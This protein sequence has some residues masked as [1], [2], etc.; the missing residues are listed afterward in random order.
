[1]ARLIPIGW[2]CLLGLLAAAQTRIIPHV[3][4][5]GGG[6]AT[7]LWVENL[8]VGQN[9]VTLTP[10]SQDGQ[11]LEAITPTLDSLETRVM[12]SAQWFS[13]AEV[14]H[15]VIEG[16]DIR[17]TAAYR[18]ASGN[19]S[20]AHV[21]ETTNAAHRYRL[22]AGN[23]ESV[24][25]GI[26]VVNLGDG[27]ADVRIAQKS[28]EGEETQVVLAAQALP[29]MAKALYVIGGPDGSSFEILE[30]VYYEVYSD[31]PIALTSLRGNQPRAEFL[32]VNQAEI[33]TL[34]MAKVID[35]APEASDCIDPNTLEDNATD[36]NNM[37]Q[38]DVSLDAAE[39]GRLGASAL[40]YR[41][42]AIGNGNAGLRGW[43]GLYVSNDHG[44]HWE[45]AMFQNRNP[46]LGL[47]VTTTG[48]FGLPAGNGITFSHQT[49]QT[50]CFDRDGHLYS[51]ARL[52]A[53]AAGNST[54]S[55]GPSA[56]VFSRAP[57]ES[58]AHP[59]I[60]HILGAV[61]D[62]SSHNGKP[63]LAVD[64]TTGTAASLVAIAWKYTSFPEGTRVRE[65]VLAVSADGGTSFSKPF[66]IPSADLP[67]TLFSRVDSMLIGLDQGTTKKTLYLVFYDIGSNAN[68]LRVHLLKAALEPV[69]TGNTEA[70][71]SHLRNPQNWSVTGDIVP[72][73]FN[74]SAAH[75]GGTMSYTPTLRATMDPQTGELFVILDVLDEPTSGTKVVIFKSGDSGTTWSL[76]KTVDY[77]SATNQI[78]PAIAYRNGII[79]TVWYDGRHNTA[80][81]PSA[82]FPLIDVYYAELDKDLNL[83][84]EERVTATSQI[85]NAN[86]FTF[87]T[88]QPSKNGQ[89]AC[90][91]AGYLGSKIGIAANDDFSFIGWTDFRDIQHPEVDLCTALPCDGRRNTNIYFARIRKQGHGMN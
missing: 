62:P 32:W 78:L 84:R 52:S 76:P 9:T 21:P 49:D 38:L 6:F 74:P 39:D 57:K 37:P 67:D 23:W 70:L 73:L 5:S 54:P 33:Q 12:S 43:G 91:P 66:T 30:D 63:Q 68:D 14:S 7:D 16:T 3:T 82:P 24:F 10:Y 71:A 72:N 80:F 87:E 19:P 2:I 86:T 64:R 83:L 88:G 28:L 1:M 4:R 85:A 58:P 51:A 55:F 89:K 17:V 59:S 45:N 26:A 60:T 27:P 81:Q 50:L 29:M 48:D 56:L 61:D 31:Q 53:E 42:G 36:L 13:G 25:D 15:V 90:F 20:P 79:S 41:Y 40:D 44:S 65:N 77:P 47:T 11:Q 35:D 69:E 46:N 22:F 8:A 75:I 34:A 18:L